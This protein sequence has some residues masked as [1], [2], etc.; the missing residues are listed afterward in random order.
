MQISEVSEG[1]AV[2]VTQRIGGYA[3]D[4]SDTEGSIWYDSGER[5]RRTGKI[6]EVVQDLGLVFCKFDDG[7]GATLASME[8]G[9]LCGNGVFSSIT[10][11]GRDLANIY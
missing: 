5:V 9:E 3:W 2:V 8:R 7:D 4:G 10:I 11:D 6:D 1:M